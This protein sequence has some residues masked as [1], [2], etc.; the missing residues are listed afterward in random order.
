MWLS[1]HTA[2]SVNIAE[3]SP[4]ISGAADHD[5]VANIDLAKRLHCEAVVV[6]GGYHFSGA[7]TE[8]VEASQ[9]RL[10]RAVECA[11]SQG[12][13]LL[14]ENLNFEPHDAEIHY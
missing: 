5:L 2:S 11:E 1:L 9:E 8:R 14:L 6:H 3:F 13:V 10:K 4:F 7:A 12:V